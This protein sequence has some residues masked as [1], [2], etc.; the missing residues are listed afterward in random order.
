MM[1]YMVEI[2]LPEDPDIQFYQLI[3]AQKAHV[4]KLMEDGSIRQYALSHDR[5]RLWIIALGSEEAEIWDM[6]AAFPMIA[7]MKPKVTPLMFADSM[8]SMLPSFSLN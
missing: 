3:P 8:E 6:L 4:D 2:E 7:F 1:F 5:S